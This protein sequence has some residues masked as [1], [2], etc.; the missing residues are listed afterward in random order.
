MT[1]KKHIFIS[2]GE[3]SGDIHASGLISELL[4][5]TPELEI[6]GLGG[7]NLQNLGTKLLYHSRDLAAMGFWEVAT[8]IGFFMKVKRDCHRFLKDHKPDLIILVDYPGLNLNLAKA[9]FNLGIPVV[10][11]IMPQVWAWKPK[12]IY[13]LKKYC[14]R[15]LSILPFEVEFFNKFDTEI[16]F[17]GHPMIDLISPT[18]N[19]SECRQKLQLEDNMKVITMLP[20]SRMQV[21]NKNL[22]VMISALRILHD[23]Y[24]NVSGIIVKAPDL[25]TKLYQD[26]IG[27]APDNVKIIDEDKYEYM[28]ASDAVMV[29]SGTATLETALC[30]TP[31]V[32]IYRTSQLTYFLVKH[33][34]NI[35]NI[36]LA[37]LVAGETVFPE[38]IQQKATP[39][40][41][42]AAISRYIDDAGYFDNVLERISQIRS[43]LEPKGAY[44]RGA[45][46]IYNHFLK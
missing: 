34:I 11:F 19:P 4:R 27:N 26:L 37:N 44:A 14:S 23:K 6:S 17:I 13:S 2:A 46:I 42:A 45:E 20:G 33:M 24:K 32:V 18:V 31:G 10:Y 16:D 28:K 12:R 35:N 43:K 7:S 8:K 29:A 15:L 3:T 40:N 38:L 39:E 25:K 41:I 36:A 22:P 21:M 1:S 5:L 30:G 9:A